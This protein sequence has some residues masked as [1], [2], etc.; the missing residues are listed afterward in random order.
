MLRTPTISVAVSEWG[1]FLTSFSGPVETK[2]SISVY[3]LDL[4]H[5]IIGYCFQERHL[6]SLTT[7]ADTE[8][9]IHKLGNYLHQRDSKKPQNI[10]CFVVG[11]AKLVTADVFIHAF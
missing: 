8:P 5:L 10:R 6:R 3:K 7:A 11:P 9:F 4:K 1:F 2:P